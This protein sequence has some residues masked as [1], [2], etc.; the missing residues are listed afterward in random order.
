VAGDAPEYPNTIVVVDPTTASV[1]SAIPVGSNPHTLALSE[2]GS[3]LWVGID[4]ARSFR[5]VTLTATPPT[6]GALRH[7]PKATPSSYFNARSMATLPGAPQS[8]AMLMSD[9]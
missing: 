1:V 6:L 9:D 2:D 8:I 7:L 4:G 3:T 5:S